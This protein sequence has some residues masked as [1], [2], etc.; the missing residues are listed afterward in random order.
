LLQAPEPWLAVV[1]FVLYVL[2]AFVLMLTSL[3]ALMS[4]TASQVSQ[5]RVIIYGTRRET[6]I[7]CVMN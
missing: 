1:L 4:N 2:L 6:L 7:V 5:N 3:F